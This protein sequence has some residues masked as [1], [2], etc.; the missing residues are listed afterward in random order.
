MVA[1]KRTDPFDDFEHPDLDELS[2]RQLLELARAATLADAMITIFN[3]NSTAQCLF[4]V[5]LASRV[6]AEVDRD[7]PREE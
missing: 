3:A 7:M 5:A 4:I 1:A 2:D 6:A